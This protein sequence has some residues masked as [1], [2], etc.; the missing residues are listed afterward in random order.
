MNYF[1]SY[2]SKSTHTV[3]SFDWKTVIYIHVCGLCRTQ[4]MLPNLSRR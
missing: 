4:C 1:D 3:I 2:I